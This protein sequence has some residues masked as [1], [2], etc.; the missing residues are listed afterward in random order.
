MQ[1]KRSK[2]L[3]ANEDRHWTDKV[4]RII[5]EN[6]HEAI[7]DKE[8]FTQ[9]RKLLDRKIKASSFSSDRGKNI[10]IKQDKFAGILYCG[11]CG[12]RIPQL[13]KLVDKNGKLVRE[14]FYH[15]NSSKDNKTDSCGCYIMQFNLE[16]VVYRTMETQVSLFV[17]DVAKT[18][19]S[20]EKKFTRYIS[21][22]DKAVADLS[23]KISI[24]EHEG[25][26]IYGNYVS[27]EISKEDLV[28][29]Q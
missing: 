5:V 22:Y 1:G 7:I 4:D 25:S 17:D 8:T 29:K 12:K 9:I 13:S 24:E 19:D 3:F 28:I 20:V 14:Y 27:G 23:K 11:V 2:R 26:R 15:C 18:I 16:T 6:A 21:T 10:P